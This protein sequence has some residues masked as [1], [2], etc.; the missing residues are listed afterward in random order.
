MNQLLNQHH[1][2]IKDL[3]QL[4]NLSNQTII[5]M[6]TGVPGVIRIGKVSNR[7]RTRISLRIP[8][9]VAERVYTQTSNTN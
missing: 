1:Y 7:R 4:W 5:R 9:S 3:S 8:E 6:F 2:T